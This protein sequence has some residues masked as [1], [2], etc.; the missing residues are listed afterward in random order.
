M[1]GCYILP[2]WV[3]YILRNYWR[4]SLVSNILWMPLVAC[5]VITKYFNA[6][7]HVYLESICTILF[8]TQMYIVCIETFI[9]ED[10]DIW[11]Q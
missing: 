2:N 3:V 5:S 10:V 4:D 1:C 9:F 11:L 8:N 7:I 6:N